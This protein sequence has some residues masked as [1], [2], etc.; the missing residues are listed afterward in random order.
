MA[1]QSKLFRGDSKLEA[2]AQVASA[3]ILQGAR[4]DHVAKIQQALIELD[5]AKIGSDGIYGPATAAAVLAYKRKRNIINT[6]YQTQADDIVG[7]MTMARLDSEMLAKESKPTPP[8]PTPPPSPT[9]SLNLNFSLT[10]PSI[11]VTVE[12]GVQ[13]APITSISVIDPLTFIFPNKMKWKDVSASGKFA[14][15]KVEKKGNIFWVLMFVPEGTKS[16]DRGYVFFH[17]SP[18]QVF[19]ERKKGGKL[20]AHVVADDKNYEKFAS[21]W[22]GLSKRYL[23]IVGPQLGSAKK[24]TLILPMMRMAAFTSSTATTDVFADRPLD[25]LLELLQ[26]ARTHLSDLS[27][28]TAPT[29]LGPNSI[30]TSSFSSGIVFHASLFDR[31]K[32]SGKLVEA[33]DFDSTFIVTAHKDISASTGGP[34]VVRHTQKDRRISGGNEFH[35]PIPRWDTAAIN[36]PA[37]LPGKLTSGDVHHRICDHTLHGAVAGSSLLSGG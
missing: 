12:G 10:D 2:A 23:N 27:I 9:P 11:N 31:I 1:L 13:T 14:R 30:A 6:S 32:N 3:H 35:F 7:I 19:V 4:G 29:E 25:T 20:V 16:F 26:A 34:R 17:P 5:A 33:V 36:A 37:D 18:V 24:F 21:D 22:D 15:F 8:G 28:S